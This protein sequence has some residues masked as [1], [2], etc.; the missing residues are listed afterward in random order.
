MKT[1]LP[2]IDYEHAVNRI[3]HFIKDK[4][5]E[6]ELD[7]VVIGLSG[8]V[9]SS[10]TTVLAVK[11]LGKD[12]VNVLILPDEFTPKVDLED[13]ISL[14]KSLSVK[15]QVVN[16]SKIIEAFKSQIPFFNDKN[17]VAGGNIR[18][19]VRM[20][21]LY[22]YANVNNL[23]VCGT[24]DK[25]EILLGY[26]TKYGDGGADILPLGDLYKTQVRV[27]GRRLGLPER[28]CNK[29]SSPRLW[30]GQ[31][32]EKE[33]GVSY[34]VIDTIL[35]LYFDRGF[36]LSDIIG[37]T[38]I[39]PNIIKDIIYRAYINE[40]KR[41]TPPIPKISGV[42]ISTDWKMPWKISGEVL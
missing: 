19:R 15:Y 37:Y 5:R 3:K 27:L 7:G 18:A 30:R 14:T 22:Y 21:I 32:A 25:S 10:V 24:S 31:T 8:G 23:L 9:D 33:L 35:Y 6:S 26:F 20:I 17:I 36:S 28:I 11:A 13:A 40:H 34:E 2:H 1:I 41:N 16:I 12:N 29:P 42:S 4:L 38:K 39:D